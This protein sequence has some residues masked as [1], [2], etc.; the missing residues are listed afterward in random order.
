MKDIDLDRGRNLGCTRLDQQ[1][2]LLT[3]ASQLAPL[4]RTLLIS[5]AA[6]LVLAG[7]GSSGTVSKNQPFFTSGNREADQRASQRMAKAEQLAGSGEGAGE[8]EASGSSKTPSGSSRAAGS[9]GGQPQPAMAPKKQS[10]FDRLGGESGLAAI[11]ND[12]FPRVMQDPRVNWD[13]KGVKHGGLF[14]RGPSVTW[15]PTPQNVT[16]VKKHMLE[17]LALATG[18]P[19]HYDGEA[20]KSAHNGMQISNPEFDAAVGDLKATLDNLKI[21]NQEQKE[22]LAIIESTR[23]EIVT[24]R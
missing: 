10:L 13:R 6:A 22:L 17:F 11:M 4:W 23:E 20:I 14:H 1:S 3:V 24:V 12:F 2:A 16:T 5:T 18:G 15:N 8:K 19:A 9:G 7:C 21:A